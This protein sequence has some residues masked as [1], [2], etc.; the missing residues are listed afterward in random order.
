M[1]NQ[2]NE[3]KLKSPERRGNANKDNLH[4]KEQLINQNIKLKTQIFDLNRELD[5]IIAKDRLRK[6]KY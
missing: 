3:S 5:D 6:K 2:L 4:Q 1:S